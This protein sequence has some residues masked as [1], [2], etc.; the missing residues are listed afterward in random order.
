MKHSPSIL[1][2]FAV[3]LIALSTAKGLELFEP[4]GTEDFNGRIIDITHRYVPEMPS[5]GTNK[6]L[7]QILNRTTDQ[8]RNDLTTN[9]ELKMPVHSGT[10]TDAP[11]HVFIEYLE[12]GY[13][14]DSLKLETLNGPV[15]L[16]DVPRNMN[17][18]DIAL[19]Q[20]NI[21]KG[22]KRVLFR[23]LNTDRKLMLQ[24]EFDSSYVGFTKSGASWLIKNTDIKLVGV[25]YLSVA[26]SDYLL[27][28]HLI[29]LKSREIVVVEGLNL[30]KIPAGPYT[31]H[32]LPLRLVGADASPTRCILIK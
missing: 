11:S 8:R 24:K 31:L 13:D 27:P 30:D 3:V 26:A 1:L 4:S 29:L 12:K 18:S 6:G 28:A 16:V 23:T 2:T 15:L 5:Y 21:P 17:I 25:D 7:R 10:H 20:M 22:V 14:I 9:S 32:C 19:S